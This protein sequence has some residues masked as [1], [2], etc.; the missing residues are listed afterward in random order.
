MHY[1]TSHSWRQDAEQPITWTDL[2]RT[3]RCLGGH[4]LLQTFPI[5]LP[6][7]RTW[8]GT[9]WSTPTRRQGRRVQVQ[10]EQGVGIFDSDDC[11]DQANAQNASRTLAQRNSG[12]GYP[13]R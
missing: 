4:T 13:A 10:D 5:T 2:S 8:A 12:T 11:F 9:L 7:G 6:D 1:H 3:S